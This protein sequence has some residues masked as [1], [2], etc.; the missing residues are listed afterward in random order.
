[1]NPH[2]APLISPPALIAS[3]WRHRYLIFQMAKR[4]VIGRY[5]GSVVGLLWSFLNPVFML[6]MYTFVFS[7]VFKARW[8]VAGAESRGQFAL[9]L[10]VGMIVHSLFAEVLNRAPG[11]IV[12][13]VSYVKKIVF[14]LEVF[15]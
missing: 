3:L 13:N 1:M 15:H 4:E 12:G 10:F 2:A 6:S 7:V 8:G 9:V 5:K 14:P 11:L